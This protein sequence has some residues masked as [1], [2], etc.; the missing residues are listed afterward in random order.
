MKQ[1]TDRH[2]CLGATD[3]SGLYVCL[4]TSLC[5]Q[6]TVLRGICGA[7]AR[8]A[9]AEAEPRRAAVPAALQRELGDAT[10]ETA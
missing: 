3:P 5:A 9:T 10:H 6:P 8:Q 2:T 4:Q 1:Q 7:A